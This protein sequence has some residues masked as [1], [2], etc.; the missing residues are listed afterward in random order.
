MQG[1]DC[2]QTLTIL[3]PCHAG[4]APPLPHCL[5]VA[6]VFIAWQISFRLSPPT[7]ETEWEAVGKKR[8]DGRRYLVHLPW[9][10][11]IS[12]RWL[13]R[14]KHEI[15][16]QRGQNTYTDLHYP[17]V[18]RLIELIQCCTS[19]SSRANWTSAWKET[20]TPQQAGLKL[21]LQVSPSLSRLIPSRRGIPFSK[22]EWLSEIC[23]RKKIM[24]EVQQRKEG[25]KRCDKSLPFL[26]RSLFPFHLFKS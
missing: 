21:A 8:G 24:K 13:T 7:E 20:S 4:N 26:T 22:K 12:R 3:I 6:F 2:F 16:H 25:M 11:C 17:T 10:N 1:L 19:E 9:E 18:P 14:H 23:Q 15:R 5:N